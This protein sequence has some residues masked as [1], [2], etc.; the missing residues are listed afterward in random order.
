LT[1]TGNGFLY[2]MM[3]IIAGT[4]AFVGLGLLPP[5]TVEKA[6]EKKDRTLTGMTFPP[7]GLTLL[8]FPVHVLERGV[9]GKRGDNGRGKV[10]ERVDLQAANGHF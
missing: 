4:V 5:D 8:L 3:R 1:V 7:Q 6:F 10:I 9:A 2:N